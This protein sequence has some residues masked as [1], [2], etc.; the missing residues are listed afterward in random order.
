MTALSGTVLFERS[1]TTTAH[2]LESDARL[3]AWVGK[4]VDLWLFEDYD[5]RS[6][7]AACLAARGIHARTHS[8]YKPLIH[9][10]LEEVDLAGLV[11]VEID[12]PVHP[13]ADVRRFLC[14][15]YPLGALLDGVTLTWKAIPAAGVPVYALR[16]H[17]GPDSVVSHHQVLAPNLVL[18]DA[19]GEKTFSPT[20][21]LTVADP[22]GR[23]AL[24][25]E[26][27]QT[28]L[29]TAFSLIMQ[30]LAA[31]DWGRHEPYFERLEIRVDMPGAEVCMPD[32][33]LLLS[34]CEALHEDLYF[35]LLE[36][37]QQ[38]SG[39][40]RGDRGLQ[41][42]QVVPDIRC[43]SEAAIRVRV[44]VYSVGASLPSLTALPG[45]AASTCDQISLAP[46]NVPG[47]P[48]ALSLLDRPIRAQDIEAALQTM[49]GQRFHFQSRQDRTLHGLWHP[50]MLPA[51]VVTGGQH[52]N[53]AS[54]VVGALRGAQW[55]A[56]QPGAHFA[57]VPLEN[58]DG[59]QL[60]LEYC[61]IH[62][63]HMHHA[64]RYT[65]LGDDLEYREHAPWYERAGRQHAL[66]VTGAQLHLS[67]HGYPAH[68]WT[69]PFTGYLPR[70]FE[71]WSIPKGFFLILRYRE[72]WKDRA[73]LLLE[74]LTQQLAQVPGL[75]PFNAAQLSRYAEHTGDI[76][77]EVRHGIACLLAQNDRQT[78]GVVLV[79]E[80]PD[81]TIYGSDF[82]FAHQVQ[83]QTV[84]LAAAIWWRLHGAQT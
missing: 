19:L 39:R 2:A 16:L 64:A 52:A 37:F 61:A 66:A 54:G 8:A 43:W 60:F 10:F 46:D 53:E 71:L 29:Q 48:P 58:P 22:A 20:G 73:M 25:T 35:S 49:Q 81:E 28:T 36:F 4:M 7:L 23:L 55:L 6:R 41:P 75:A 14:E 84:R 65:G 17:R 77:F 11:A 31:Y 63:Q 45:H 57:L 26:P 12:Y 59:Y 5:A 33:K 69:R 21:W 40:P 38:Y 68:E 56:D 76:P 80:F 3:D 70:G 47:P 72:G 9:F 34:I 1:L 30:T 18:T 79:T 27:L 62:P 42:G 13:L 74:S 82:V 78:P 67:L 50:G 44:V 24:S 32:G 51:I 15:A 83:A